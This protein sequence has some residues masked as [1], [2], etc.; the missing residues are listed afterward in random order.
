M[1]NS[2]GSRSDRGV[3]PPTPDFDGKLVFVTVADEQAP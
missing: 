1:L 2:A 3:T